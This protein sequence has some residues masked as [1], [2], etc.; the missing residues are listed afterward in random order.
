MTQILYSIQEEDPI[1]IDD[2][3]DVDEEYEDPEEKEELI[4]MIYLAQCMTIF[5]GINVRHNKHFIRHVK[6]TYFIK[7]AGQH[8]MSR[9]TMEKMVPSFLKQIRYE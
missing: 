1:N 6:L 5:G 4:R 3:I 8:F 9:G 7:H 2:T